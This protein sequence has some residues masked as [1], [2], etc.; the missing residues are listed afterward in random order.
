[1]FINILEFSNVFIIHFLLFTFVFASKYESLA[2]NVHGIIF[3]KQ[4]LLEYHIV[5]TKL[6]LPN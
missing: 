2:Y 3:L 1:M 4:E 5:Y 6:K